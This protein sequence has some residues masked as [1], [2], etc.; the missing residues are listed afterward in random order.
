M[1]PQFLF[2]L[3]LLGTPLGAEEPSAQARADQ[4][5]QQGVTAMKAGQVETART[6]FRNALQLNPG[7]PHA[8][9]QLLELQRSSGDVAAKARERRLAAVVIREVDFEDSTLS[10]VLEGLAQLVRK[11]TTDQYSP[12]FVV[13]DPSKQFAGKKINVQL[14]NVPASGVLKYA[15]EQVHGIAKYDEHAVV[16]RPLGNGGGS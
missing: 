2:A 12:N 8:R 9:Y 6:A 14:R 7:H 3:M 13:Q 16:I 11:N 10:E 1:K 4:F 15:L 5:Y